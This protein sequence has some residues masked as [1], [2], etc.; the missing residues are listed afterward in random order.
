[1]KFKMQRSAGKTIWI[2]TLAG[3]AVWYSPRDMTK[4]EAWSQFA[5]DLGTAIDKGTES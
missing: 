3:R 2:V 5:W 4:H 1:M